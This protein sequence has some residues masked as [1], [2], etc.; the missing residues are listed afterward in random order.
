MGRIRNLGWSFHGDIAAFDF[1]L[2]QDIQWDFAQIQLNYQDWQHASPPDVNTN[3]E[4]LYSELVKH[5]VPAII[6][7]PLLGGRLARVPAQVLALMKEVHPKATPAQW[8]FRTYA[9]LVPL[10]EQE[11]ATLER[12]TDVLCERGQDAENFERRQL[13]D[14]ASRVP[15]WLRP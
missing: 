3:A 8:A 7:E 1:L 15:D 12:V 2:A 4:Y 13:P 9:S 5:N 11:Y 14:S 10:N 6:M